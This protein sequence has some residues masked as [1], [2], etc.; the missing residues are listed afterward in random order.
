MRHFYLLAIAGLISFTGFTAQAQSEMETGTFIESVMQS[1][2]SGNASSEIS[3]DNVVQGVTSQLMGTVTP[4]EQQTAVI[5]GPL[6]VE[7]VVPAV[8]QTVVETIDART[9]RYP[10]RLKINFA[11]F[12]LRSLTDMNRPKNGRNG[13]SGTPTEMIA[14]RI[15]N[16]L[17]VPE[18]QLTIEDRTALVSGTVTTE[19]ERELIATMLRFEPGIGAVKNEITVAP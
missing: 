8:N 12:P 2:T 18:F 6:V 3:I 7:T 13:Q 19:R 17:R 16:R 4:M 1:L 14:Q 9:G 5:E 11:E 15:Q 10:P